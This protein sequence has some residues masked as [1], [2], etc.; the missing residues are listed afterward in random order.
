MLKLELRWPDSALMPNRKN[1]RH[2][3]T[4]HVI[5]GQAMT[6]ARALTL[7]AMQKSKWVP[8]S[9]KLP[10]TITFCQP[11]KRRRDLD[12][13]LASIKPH[14]DGISQALGIDDQ[15]FEPI[16]LNRGEVVKG[17]RVIVEIGNVD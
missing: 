14:C 15:Y 5:K 7:Q 9:G 12:N 3:T 4:V 17:G 6:E 1:G 10:I 13:L 11:D 2:W 8:P 16:T